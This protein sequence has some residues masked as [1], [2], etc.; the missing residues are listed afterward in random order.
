M[1]DT[2]A[3]I[4]FTVALVLPGFLVVQ[5]SERRRP[6]RPPG[7]DLELVLRGLVYALIIQV[8]AALTTWL[9]YLAHKLARRNITDH[10]SALA[11]YA[12]IV[13]V[14]TPTV[15][16]LLLG[17]WLRSAESDGALKWWHYALG[18]RDSRRAWDYAFSQHGG[19]WLRVVLREPA[20]GG[21]V[22]YLGKYGKRSWASQSP[23]DPDLYL[24]EF[25]PTGEDGL[26]AEEEIERGSSGGMWING[27]QI[28]RIELLS[29]AGH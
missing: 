2:L 28:A 25:W 13:C 12:L 1:F 10:F 22:A 7:G 3:E 15:I 6:S 18:A 24:Q 9:P 21:P 16:G 23:A 11:L 14:V 19:S 8:I 5:L 20:A 26:V 4:A 29:E 27:D 17:T